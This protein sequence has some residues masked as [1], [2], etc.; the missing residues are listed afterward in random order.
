MPDIISA[1]LFA[2]QTASVVGPKLLSPFADRFVGDN[3]TAFE[4]H[5]LDMTKAERKSEI[6]PHRMGDDLRRETMVL[7]AD[8]GRVHAGTLSAKAL[9]TA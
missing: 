9:T 3:D 4:Q 2:A 7:V 5:L 8:G 6:Q 1:G